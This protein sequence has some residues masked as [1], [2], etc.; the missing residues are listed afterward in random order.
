MLHV[1]PKVLYRRVRLWAH[2]SVNRKILLAALTVGGG[3]AAVKGTAML[4]ELVIAYYFGTADVLDAF[5]I[6]FMVPSFAVNVVAGAVEAAFMPTYIE[7]LEQQ[8]KREA[9]RLLGSVMVGLGGLLALVCGAMAIAG[10]YLITLV[11]AG[12]TE[13]KLALTE[14]FYYLLLPVTVIKGIAILW[15]RVLN[16]RNRFALAAIAPAMLPLAL[17][18]FLLTLGDSW[19]GYVLVTGTLFG[20]CAEAGV[21][22]CGLLRR[23][24]W[25]WPEWGGKTEAVNQAWDQF[26]PLIIGSLLVSSAPLIDKSMATVLGSGKVAVLNYGIKVPASIIGLGAMSLSTAVLPHFSK[27]AAVKKWGNILET[28]HKYILYVLVITL[29][30]TTGLIIFS[31]SLATLLYNRGA[32]TVKDAQ[33]VGAVQA[34]YFLQIPAN[35]ISTIAVKLISSLK[36]SRL[37]MWGAGI[38]LFVNILMNYILMK[39]IGIKGIALSTSIVYLVSSVYLYFMVRTAL[40]SSILEE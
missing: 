36:Y 13:E 5:L 30:L 39:W 12:F 26:L 16:A 40:K 4:K 8:G 24:L 31:D 28:F 34:F 14:A 20:Y 25:T 17:I 7:V 6:A 27:M 32:F 3:T 35:I 11:G 21:L 18:I 1:S 9:R 10:P 23:D 37:L 22:M 29:P 19:G 15:A 33:I 2:G 38:N